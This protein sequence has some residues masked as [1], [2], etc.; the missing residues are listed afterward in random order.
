M[1]ENCDYEEL[2]VYKFAPP[3]MIKG[4]ETFIEKWEEEL[5]TAILNRV[6]NDLVENEFCY[7]TTRACIGVD[8]A[9]VPNMPDHITFDGK[10]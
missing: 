9:N 8:L 10:K 6:G 3:K 1:S 5:E 7:K 4:C 2:R